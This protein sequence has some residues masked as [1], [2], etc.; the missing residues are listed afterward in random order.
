MISAGWIVVA[1]FLPDTKMCAA[2]RALA[3]LV[4]LLTWYYRLA[5]PHI[6]DVQVR[7][8]GCY[9]R[10]NWGKPFGL[11][12]LAFIASVLLLTLLTSF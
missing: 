11:A 6:R 12:F 1:S 5:E 10:R 3:T 9:P 8:N 7:F 4:L 2:F